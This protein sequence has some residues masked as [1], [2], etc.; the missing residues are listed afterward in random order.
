[1]YRAAPRTWSVTL[2]RARGLPVHTVATQSPDGSV[3]SQVDVAIGGV[4]VVWAASR[5]LAELNASALTG[6]WLGCLVHSRI[7]T[8]GQR[9]NRGSP[10]TRARPR[11]HRVAPHLRGLCLTRIARSDNA[12]SHRR[13]R[14]NP[15]SAMNSTPPGLL[16]QARSSARYLCNQAATSRKWRA[17]L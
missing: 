14:W 17:T 2:I 16:Q 11:L 9:C 15:A 5:V 1:M 6:W 8:R 13:H 7:P 4:Q 3:S 12:C 10:W